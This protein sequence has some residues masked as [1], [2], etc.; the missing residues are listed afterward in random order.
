ML[1]PTTYSDREVFRREEKKRTIIEREQ[2]KKDNKNVVSQQRIATERPL[3]KKRLER[4]NK[5]AKI[6]NVVSQLSVSQRPTTAFNQAIRPLMS[7][8]GFRCSVS[9]LT[10]CPP[11]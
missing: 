2:T 9:G 5:Q 8:A 3:D 7:A 11:P 6:K 4:E 10:R 1:F